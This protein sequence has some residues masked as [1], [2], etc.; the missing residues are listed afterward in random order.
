MSW[1]A[2]EDGVTQAAGGAQDSGGM[3]VPPRVEPPD[4]RRA[5][6]RQPGTEEA[7]TLEP[8]PPGPVLGAA[9]PTPPQ[10]MAPDPLAGPPPMAAT[11]PVAA[12]PG[13][14]AVTPEAAVPG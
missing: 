3:T 6:P 8:P 2:G 7:L 12:G 5:W 14:A 11:P 1:T 10:T 4:S 9:S 13:L